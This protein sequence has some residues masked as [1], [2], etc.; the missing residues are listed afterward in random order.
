MSGLLRVRGGWQGDA[1]GDVD[2]TE[3]ELKKSCSSTM[4]PSLILKGH[5]ELNSK[6]LKI[7]RATVLDERHKCLQSSLCVALELVA[8]EVW[9][10]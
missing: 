7:R 1:H 10:S 5:A 4:D 9:H 8:E 3:E 2:G 6:Y